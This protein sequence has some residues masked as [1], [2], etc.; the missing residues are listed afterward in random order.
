MKDNRVAIVDASEDVEAAVR[1]S[2]ELLGGLGLEGGEHVIIK[3]NLCNAKNPHGMVITDF[4]VIEAII[5]LIKEKTDKITVVESD[6][7]SDTADNRAEKSGLLN[8]L[9]GMGVEFF[10]LSGDEY[11]VH[12]VAGKKLRLPKTVLEADYVNLPKIKTEGH[13]GV[14]LSIKNLFGLLCRRKKSRLHGK[15]NEILPYLAKVIRSDLILVD[16]IVAMEGNGPIIGTPKELGIIVAGT[17]PL[18]TDAICSRI[19]GFDPADI[20]YLVRTREMGLG[21]IDLDKIEVVGEDWRRFA[22]EFERPYSFKAT[23]KSLKSIGER[24]LPK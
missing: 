18:S 16:G 5:S 7:I 1:R 6:N 22:S 9:D 19:M 20:R 15:L 13:V 17:T 3:P 24:Y 10:N 11:E 4:R 14:T 2:V 21:E 12:E 8:L 23:L